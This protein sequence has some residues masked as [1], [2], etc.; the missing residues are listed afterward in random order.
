MAFE[1]SQEF[2]TASLDITKDFCILHSASIYIC[3]SILKVKTYNWL[4]HTHTHTHASNDYK[5]KEQFSN[6][7]IKN[8]LKNK[9]FSY[10]ASILC[11]QHAIKFPQRTHR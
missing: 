3:D 6:T 7:Q 4:P 2:L 5:Q 9:T 1:M 11:L 8:K 10:R